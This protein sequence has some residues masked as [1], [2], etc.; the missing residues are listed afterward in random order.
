MP[1]GTHDYAS[2]PFTDDEVLPRTNERKSKRSHCQHCV[3]ERSTSHALFDS[4][5]VNKI[6]R[7][8]IHVSADRTLE[9]GEVEA[10][11]K[12]DLRFSVLHQDKSWCYGL[13]ESQVS[14]AFV[15][16]LNGQGWTS[17][18]CDNWVRLT[19]GPYSIRFPALETDETAREV[20]NGILR[21]DFNVTIPGSQKP[22]IKLMNIFPLKVQ[23]IIRD[24]VLRES[25]FVRKDCK[26]NFDFKWKIR[27]VIEKETWTFEHDR[28]CKRNLFSLF[29]I[30]FLYVNSLRKIV[31]EL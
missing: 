14:C 2:P 23:E 17:T 26:L 25:D 12:D 19:I 24:R 18:W 8:R 5:L 20:V 10:N 4:L 11:D 30:I 16:P 9:A 13:F 31:S 3:H 7:P 29:P 6:R 27:F 1:R 28:N 15:R 21:E 22:L